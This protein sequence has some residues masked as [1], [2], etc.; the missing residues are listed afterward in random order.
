MI[1]LVF[2]FITHF[3]FCEFRVAYT[4]LDKHYNLFHKILKIHLI[5][6]I[7]NY[8]SLERTTQVDTNH[9]LNFGSIP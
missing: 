7:L 6:L 4:G 3:R 1:L 8:I 2:L 9:L 5:V